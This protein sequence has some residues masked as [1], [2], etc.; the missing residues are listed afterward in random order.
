MSLFFVY[1]Y[2][3]FSSSIMLYARLSCVNTCA[4]HVYFTI[5]VL[6]YLLSAALCDLRE[7]GGGGV[8]WQGGGRPRQVD[9]VV[10]HVG[11]DGFV[12]QH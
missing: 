9:T 10:V 8:G 6:T 4:C 5:N 7:C 1:V 3:L 2:V 12:K 11:D